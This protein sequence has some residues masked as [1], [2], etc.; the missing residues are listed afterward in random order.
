MAVEHI[1]FAHHDFATGGPEKL[2]LKPGALSVLTNVESGKAATSTPPE[3][4]L[5]NVVPPDVLDAIAA[6]IGPQRHGESVP[7]TLLAQGRREGK[8]RA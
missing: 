1:N 4:P 5:K 6:A 3:N 2:G 8:S 7:P